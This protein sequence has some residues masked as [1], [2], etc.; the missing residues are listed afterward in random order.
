MTEVAQETEAEV[1]EQEI[2]FGQA[3]AEEPRGIDQADPE[4]SDE[5]PVQEDEVDVL[6]VLVPKKD[7]KVW[8]IGI[9]E[10]ERTYIQRKLSFI[11]KMQWFS[12]VGE[13][14]DKALSGPNKMSMNSLLTGAPSPR[15][16]TL[17][18]ADFTDADTFV[19][20]L[21]KLLSH[22]PDFL[23]D[24]YAIWLGVPAS[25]KELAKQIFAL[26]EEDG[27]LSDDQ[28]MEI[29]EVFIDQNYDALDDFF[30]RR[31]AELRRRVA[32]NADEAKESRRSRR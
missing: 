5:A 16:G 7:P 31:I 18:V 24:S 28:G 26:P 3:V 17:S 29:I 10:Y 32:Q 1:Q 30:R 19:Q 9:G 15:T 11:A 6:D 23:L 13:V 20:A 2:D 27:G 22:A 8:T 21:G 25:E 4:A 12:L 14:L